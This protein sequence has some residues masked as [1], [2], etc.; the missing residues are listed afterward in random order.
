MRLARLGRP[1]L[2]R[3]VGD[4]RFACAPEFEPRSERRERQATL[5]AALTGRPGISRKSRMSPFPFHLKYQPDPNGIN[6]RRNILFEQ[7]FTKR[8]AWL[9]HEGI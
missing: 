2:T 7:G 1:L 9:A 3:N 6:L 4:S 5:D 8:G